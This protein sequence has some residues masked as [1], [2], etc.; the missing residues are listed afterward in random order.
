MTV[1]S[2]SESVSPG[3]SKK[4]GIWNKLRKI[5]P[6]WLLVIAIYI[7][8]LPVIHSFYFTLTGRVGY[9]D[10]VLTKQLLPVVIL[11]IIISAILHKKFLGVL[12][13]ATLI[14][15]VSWLPVHNEY[16]ELFLIIFTSYA[17]LYTVIIGHV[18][19]VSF[20]FLLVYSLIFFNW[21]IA[22]ILGLFYAFCRFLFLVISQNYNVCSIIGFKK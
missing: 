15:Y 12:T 3:E 11:V 14:F 7:L 10:L 1:H 19:S 17:F 20:I 9:T 8:I 2:R 18:R 21:D 22:V 4:K 6:E 13:L 16:V 5:F